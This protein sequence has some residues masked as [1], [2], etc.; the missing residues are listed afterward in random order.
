MIFSR[1]GE[2]MWKLKN[3]D[4]VV[5]NAEK[6]EIDIYTEDEFESI[7]Q[8]LRDHLPRGGTVALD[9]EYVTFAVANCVMEGIM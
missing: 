6:G 3:K 5:I 1:T 7:M 2:T 4:V 9:G 8:E